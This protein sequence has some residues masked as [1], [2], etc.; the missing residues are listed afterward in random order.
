MEGREGHNLPLIESEVLLGSSNGEWNG[1]FCVSQ[2]AKESQ[3][4]FYGGFQ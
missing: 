3:R 2:R 1:I 4:V